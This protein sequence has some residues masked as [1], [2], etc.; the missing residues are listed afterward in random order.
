MNDDYR[1]GSMEGWHDEPE[2]VIDFDNYDE[3]YQLE[4]EI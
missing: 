1:K 3:N 4:D 2:P